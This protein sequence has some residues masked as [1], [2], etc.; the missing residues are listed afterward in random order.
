[1]DIIFSI[2]L[3]LLF[4]YLISHFF[5]LSYFLPNNYMNLMMPCST[6]SHTNYSHSSCLIQL[7]DLQLVSFIPPSYTRNMIPFSNRPDLRGFHSWQQYVNVKA[8]VHQDHHIWR[9][10]IVHKALVDNLGTIMTY[11]TELFFQYCF[12]DL[13]IGE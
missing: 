8:R 5:L 11:P 10:D 6:C 4:K 2:L 3:F 1:M 9:R 12:Q 7:L 13:G